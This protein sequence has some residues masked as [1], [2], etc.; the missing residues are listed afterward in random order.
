MP[1]HA[2][3]SA[4]VRPPEVPLNERAAWSARDVSYATGLSLRFVAKLALDGKLPSKL[5][6]RR[7]LFD[8]AAVRA[9][10]FAAE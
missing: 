6:G 2:T 7:R 10:L 1:T 4:L 3:P 5:V 9:A 8:P